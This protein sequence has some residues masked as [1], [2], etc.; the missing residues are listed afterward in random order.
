MRRPA[1]L[2]RLAAGRSRRDDRRQRLFCFCSAA[3]VGGA[4]V[5]GTPPTE[6]HL[7]A[8]HLVRSFSE[9]SAHCIAPYHPVQILPRQALKAWLCLRQPG[10]MAAA[11]ASTRVAG[12]GCWPPAS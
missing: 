1:V 11:A 12:L 5:G 2:V 3:A 7:A 6:L 10:P 4:A 9:L 8:P